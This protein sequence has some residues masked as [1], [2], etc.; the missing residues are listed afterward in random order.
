MATTVA[1]L[2][3]SVITRI[4]VGSTTLEPS[5]ANVEQWVR[6][7]FREGFGIFQP[8]FKM[9]GTVASDAVAV[10]GAD[11]ILYVLI[12]GLILAE[13]EEWQH[14]ASGVANLPRRFHGETATIYY[15][16][17]PD[18]TGSTIESSC[19]MGDDWLESYATHYA[20]EEAL[21]RLANTAPSREGQYAASLM[22][23]VNERRKDLTNQLRAERQ[24]WKA[25]MD[26]MLARRLALG[27]RVR[28]DHAWAGFTVRGGF[29][30]PLTGVDS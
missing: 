15:T 19:V 23:A 2:R 8:P 5:T 6:D 21:I 18:L 30:N 11:R 28:R 27:P 22:R 17:V 12:D 29:R 7:G 4:N 3:A 13:G 1:T 9:T 26:N 14:G 25:D 20:E 16:A 10:S 24:Q